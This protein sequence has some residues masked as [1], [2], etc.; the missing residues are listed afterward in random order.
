[1]TGW[2][3]REM[4]DFLGRKFDAID[5]RFEQI[6]L[7][8]E[9]IDRRFEGLEQRLTRV[10]VL[11][12]DTGHR[13]QLVAE[14]L[15]AFRELVERRFEDVDGEFAAVRTEMSAGFTVVRDDIAALGRRVGRLERAS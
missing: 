1:M 10:E 5:R 3:Q 7:R 2:D 11:G 4:M 12:E 13:L 15:T 9:Q 14:G 6:D 8:F